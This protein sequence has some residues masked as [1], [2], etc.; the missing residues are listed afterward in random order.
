VDITVGIYPTDTNEAGLATWTESYLPALAAKYPDVNVIPAAYEYSPDTFIPLVESGNLPD[1][2]NI[3]FTEP[4]KVIPQGIVAD[5]TD[6]LEE[7]G[8]LE[9]MNPSIRQLVS[10]EN[11]RVYGLPNN[12]YGMG[13]MINAQLF[14][15]AGLADEDGIPIYPKT[16]EEFT[17][18]A[19]KIKEE[20]GAAGFVLLAQDNAAGW[21]FVQIAWSYGAEFEKYEDGKWNA[22]INTP[23]VVAAMQMVYDWKWTYDI[24]TGD[25][26]AENWGT[27]FQQLGTGGAAMYLAADDAVSQPTKFY[28]LPI[29]DLMLVGMPAGP[30]GSVSLTGGNLFMFPA[31]TDPEVIKAGLEILEI[32]G[33]APVMTE[34]TRLGLIAG[35][36]TN[37][38]EGIPVMRSFQCWIDPEYNALCDEIYEQYVNVDPRMYEAY[39]AATTAE[40]G[41]KPEEPQYVQ[42]LYA[43]LTKVLQAVVTDQNADIQALLDQAQANFQQIL[44]DNVNK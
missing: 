33:K 4:A 27:G 32:I 40:G 8:W 25:P 35:A 1:I 11:G 12:A 28:G 36:E 16:W 17:D 7:L 31:G 9:K 23:E 41:L 15:E 42:E 22:Y 24:L 20:T 29:E 10:D 2:F 19:V 37:V 26:T 18:A 44:D 43:E 5:I 38:A 13:M 14:R 6:Q 39:Y 3:Y 30:A 34:E 21:H